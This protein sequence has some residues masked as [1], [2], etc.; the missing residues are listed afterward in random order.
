VELVAVSAVLAGATACGIT[1]AWLRRRSEAPRLPQRSRAEIE[2][3][4]TRAV[5]ESGSFIDAGSWAEALAR[6]ISRDEARLF[7]DHLAGELAS[8][9]TA[10]SL[11]QYSILVDIVF[12]LGFHADVVAGLRAAGLRVEFRA[13]AGRSNAVPLYDA[14]SSAGAAA[15]LGVREGATR[16]EVV[17]AYRRAVVA[18]HPD[19]I[20][21]GPAEARQA[22]TE[23]FIRIVA[24]SEL[25]LSQARD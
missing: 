15:L 23:R 14:H 25:L 12:G 13:P 2:D 18:A 21:D 16:Q 10:V 3:A 7:V 9:K 17:A 22:A 24:A 11:A 4:L 8:R 19:R 6:R 1:I 20:H 5:L